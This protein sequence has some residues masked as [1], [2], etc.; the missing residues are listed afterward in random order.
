MNDLYARLGYYDES[1]TSISLAGEEGAKKIKE[2][3]ANLRKDRLTAI[4][5]VEVVGWEDYGTF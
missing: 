5:G 4:N 3:I 2:I 1:Q